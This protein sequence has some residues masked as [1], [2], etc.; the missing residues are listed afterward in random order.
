MLNKMFKDYTHQGKMMIELGLF[1]VFLWAA[2]YILLV[3]AP[4]RINLTSTS[5]FLA[6]GV[7]CV[8]LGLLQRKKS[9]SAKKSKIGAMEE[10]GIVFLGIELVS[11]LLVLVFI[12]IKALSSTLGIVFVGSI[13]ISAVF[14]VIVLYIYL[15]KHYGEI[16]IL[17]PY[18]K[19]MLVI[20]IVSHTFWA[21]LIPSVV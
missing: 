3:V 8:I 16:C 12:G 17:P 19:A 7:L 9:K 6:F 2:A 14:S 4:F 1:F 13:F 21:S 15:V 5:P 10:L 20:A 11:A 18:D